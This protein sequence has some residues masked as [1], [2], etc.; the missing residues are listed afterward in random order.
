MHLKVQDTISCRPSPTL[1]IALH[2]CSSVETKNTVHCFLF[3]SPSFVF[4]VINLVP[5][6]PAIC[7]LLWQA[8]GELRGWPQDHLK[9][10]GLSI[11]TQTVNPR[12]N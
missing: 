11:Q 12:K 1:E 5:S 3:F 2:L 8:M 10:L 4:G 6:S 7:P 9:Y